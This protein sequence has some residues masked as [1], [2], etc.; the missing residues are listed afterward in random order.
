[1]ARNSDLEIVDCVPTTS[2]SVTENANNDFR[3]KLRV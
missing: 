3:C 2:R 1:M